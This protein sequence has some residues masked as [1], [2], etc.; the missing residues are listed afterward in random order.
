MKWSYWGRVVL[1]ICSF[2][3]I[4]LTIEK[5]QTKGLHKRVQETFGIDTSTQ[6]FMWCR[7]RVATVS[8]DGKKVL[9][10]DGMVWK[11][12]AHDELPQIDIEKWFGSSCRLVY[13]AAE[14]DFSSP[15]RSVEVEFIDGTKSA[16]LQNAK[17]Q[18]QW[19]SVTF[20]SPMW[21]L[22]LA[23]LEKLVLR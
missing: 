12:A 16:F 21:D 6:S 18:W 15:S 9:W 10:Q 3:A 13:S 17:G 11:S 5:L 23:E 4:V 8:F 7:S 2:V 19:E 22:Q 14:G 20:A 1:M